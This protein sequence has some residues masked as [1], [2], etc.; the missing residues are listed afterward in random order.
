MFRNKER[1]RTKTRKMSKKLTIFLWTFLNLSIKLFLINIHL[2][3]LFFKTM[4]S[5]GTRIGVMS[6]V[7]IDQ[8]SHINYDTRNFDHPSS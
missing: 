3:D 8:R 1:K 7:L 5:Y 6:P 2:I 4:L